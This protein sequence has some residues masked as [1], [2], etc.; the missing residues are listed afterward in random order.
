MDTRA[1]RL[2]GAGWLALS[3][4]IA[5][6]DA[7]ATAEYQGEALLELKGQAIVETPTGGLPVQPALCF[8][9]RDYHF[10][11]VTSEDLPPQVADAF[12]WN[13]AWPINRMHILD[14]D[15]VGQFPANF[16]IAVR[17]PPPD[18]AVRA[19]FAGEPA[20]AAGTVCAVRADHPD[21]VYPPLM[22]RQSCEDGAEPCQRRHVYA[23]LITGRY[24]VESFE[25]P[26]SETP[27]ESCARSSEGDAALEREVFEFVAGWDVTQLVYLAEPA[28]PGS[29]TA[30]QYGSP[31]GL[32]AGYHVFS[33]DPDPLSRCT[34]LAWNRARLE[35]DN[36]F[37]GK[38]VHDTALGVT[39]PAPEYEDAYQEELQRLSAQFR[40]ES[41]DMPQVTE[42]SAEDPLSIVI[43]RESS[44]AP[45]PN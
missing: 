21:V 27:R 36:R 16:N 41:C 6:C 40:M 30:W 7:Q 26:D 11:T 28:P 10:E 19:P 14:V 18:A 43:D 1:R 20:S 15:S 37:G 9:G 3:G 25:C 13:L 23:S 4:H 39:Y 2:I 17:E 38:L 45:F 34:N 12:M 8:L 44:F 24:F 31:D 5:G 29:F 33:R 32:S 42:L 35:V 22:E